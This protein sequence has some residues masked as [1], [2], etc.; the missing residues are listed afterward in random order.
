MQVLGEP[1]TVDK[2]NTVKNLTRLAVAA[3]IFW[4]YILY[5][6]TFLM[7]IGLSQR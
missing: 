1:L 3:E 2:S 6:F 5:L 4:R 7:S